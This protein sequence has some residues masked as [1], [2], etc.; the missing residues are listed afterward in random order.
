ML[1]IFSAYIRSTERREKKTLFI[2][3]DHLQ[4][5]LMYQVQFQYCFCREYAGVKG[6]QDI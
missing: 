6:S 4:S 3:G 5:L 1:T 2:S